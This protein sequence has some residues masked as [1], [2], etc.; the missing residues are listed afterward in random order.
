MQD[1]TDTPGLKSLVATQLSM[2]P[3]HQAYVETSFANRPADLFELSEQIS[4]LVLKLADRLPGG[5]EQLCSDYRYLCEE[6]LLPEQ[7]YFFRH[8]RYRLS[9]FSEAYEEW[10]A[11]DEKMGR[12]MAGVLLS[13]VFWDPHARAIGHYANRY[14]PSL[15]PGADHLEIGPGHGLLLYL[16][17]RRPG[18]RNI[19]GWDISP[20][21]LDRT[22]HALQAMDVD[23]AVSLRVQDLAAVRDDGTSTFDSVV[24]GEILEHVE[25]PASALRS[26]REILRPNGQVWINVPVNS[27]AP[28]HIYLLRTPEEAC[29]L[30]EAS[31]FAVI[32]RAF[33]PMTGFTLDDARR[34]AASISCVITGR[35][36]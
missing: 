32:D 15:P 19:V 9:S 33:F 8:G 17:A 13:Q 24:L 2:W 31:G 3:E 11:N 20:T 12:Y 29:A 18:L 25:D 5:L 1:L 22:R 6:V 7:L 36:R 35:R 27:P 34:R 26:V 30:V 14:L 10:Y 21:S 28:D 23:L 16:A 4:A